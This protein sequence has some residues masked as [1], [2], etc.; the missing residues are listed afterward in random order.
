MKRRRMLTAALMTAAA[1]AAAAGI[2]ASA[3]EEAK[4]VTVILD[5]TPNTNHTG[6]YVALDKGYYEEEGLEVEIIEPTDGATAT[7]IA[8]GKG[9]FEAT[10]APICSTAHACTS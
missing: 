10:A 7:L 5:Y 6:M 3:E 8:Q 9:T 2:T 1:L 4:K